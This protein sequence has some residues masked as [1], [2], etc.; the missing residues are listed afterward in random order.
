MLS[1]FSRVH[2]FANPWIVLCPW[3]FPGE[4]TGVGCRFFLQGVFL[5][6][7]SNLCL[8]HLLHW[9]EFFTTTC[10]GRGVNS[11]SGSREGFLEEVSLER[12]LLKGGKG[13]EG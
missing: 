12:R 13:T 9:Q 11:L 1:C 4:N 10:R 3:D 8:L 2:L 6:Q 5:I 7:G